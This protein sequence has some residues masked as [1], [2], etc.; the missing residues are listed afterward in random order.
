MYKTD[1]PNA[2]NLV[3]HIKRVIAEGQE[4]GITIKRDGSSH[5]TY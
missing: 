2:M 1:E 3:D 5:T 4:L